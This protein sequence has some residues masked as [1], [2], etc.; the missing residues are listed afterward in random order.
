M[1]K[2]A[3]DISRSESLVGLTDLQR[4]S[5]LVALAA[6][7]GTCQTVSTVIKSAAAG[8]KVAVLTMVTSTRVEKLEAIASTT[9]V[10]IVSV[11]E[12]MD[13]IVMSGDLLSDISRNPIRDIRQ[14]CP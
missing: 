5:N 9:I 10:H 7:L 8:I 12:T 6:L 3:R 13:S 4:T 14:S 2:E 11:I 1:V